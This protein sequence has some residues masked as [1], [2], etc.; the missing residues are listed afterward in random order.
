MSVSEV[1][2][3]PWF[4]IA[5][6]STGAFC[7]VCEAYVFLE[8]LQVRPCKEERC[9]ILPQDFYRT[10]VIHIALATRGFYPPKSGYKIGRIP[11]P[12]PLEVGPLESS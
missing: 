9:G 3:S 7:Y 5:S 8:L 4:G 2:Q 6:T 12:F 11:P 1:D 10:A